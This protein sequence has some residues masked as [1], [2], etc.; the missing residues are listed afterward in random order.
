MAASLLAFCSDCHRAAP[1]SEIPSSPAMEMALA[2]LAMVPEDARMVLAV[3][4]AAMRSQSLFTP[5][6]SALTRH[7]SPASGARE[8]GAFDPLRQVSRVFVALPAERQADDRFMLIADTEAIDAPSIMAYL[9]ERAPQGATA[10]V[11]GHNQV[12]LAQGAWAAAASEL[13]KTARVRPSAADDPEVFRLC[14]K[15]AGNHLVWF[16]AVVPARLRKAML[17]QTLFPDLG[18]I[19]RVSG[20]LDFEGNLHAEASAEM[21]SSA[22][23]DH[24]AHRLTVYL[25]QAKRH[26]DML[27]QGFSP[28]FDG[29]RIVAKGSRVRATLD[30]PASQAED[31]AQRI[32]ALADAHGTK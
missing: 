15:S 1:G 32:E 30:V 25:N 7:G 20:F 17:D 8:A 22:D 29:V 2:K 12:V 16:A 6:L 19:A 31:F 9:R 21:A 28:F 10:T 4:V 24:L 27:V 13:A 3:D 18:S 5:L 11:R 14:A 26:P 23:A